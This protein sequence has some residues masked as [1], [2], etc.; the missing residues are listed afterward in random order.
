MEVY[1]R[2]LVVVLAVAA[3]LAVGIFVFN[4]VTAE[5]DKPAEPPCTVY[6]SHCGDIPCNEVCF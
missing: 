3:T 5:P 4:R 6:V 2:R 1:M